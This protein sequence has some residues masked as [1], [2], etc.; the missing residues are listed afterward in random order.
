MKASEVT[1]ENDRRRSGNNVKK[2]LI[3][4]KDGLIKHWIEKKYNNNRSK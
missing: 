3:Y 2:Y 4:I 1:K